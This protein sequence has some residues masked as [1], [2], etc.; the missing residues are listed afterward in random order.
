MEKFIITQSPPLKGTVRV[1][2]SKNAALPIL[3]ATLLT[4]AQCVIKDVPELLD[5][6]RME[7]YLQT[8]GADTQWQREKNKITVGVKKI[9]STEAPYPLACSMRASFLVMGPLLARAARVKIPLPG[10]C[11]IGARP[12]DQH[13]KGLAALG[14]EITQEHGMV[15]AKAKRL[16][17]ANIYLDFPSVG[18]TENIMMAAVLARGRTIIENSAI[19]PEIVDLAGFLN[20]I[21]AD[22]R[23]AG[24]DTIRI[25]GVRGLRGGEYTIIPDRIEAGTFMVAAA[26]TRGDVLIENIV[27]DHLKPVAAKLKEANAAVEEAETGL[28]VRYV[29]RGRLKRADIKTLPYPGFPTDMQAQFMSLL[30]LAEGTS[31]ITETIFENRFMHVGELK[32]MG[33]NIKIESRSAIVEGVEKLAGTQ[34]RTTDLRAGAAL[35]LSGLIA[36]GETEIDDI[37]HIDRG[38]CKIEE[39]LRGLGAKIKRVSS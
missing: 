10:G 19:E 18:A 31:I 8:F 11:A 15:Y 12:V 6:Q 32:R 2:G 14:A 39:K 26:L 38:Y 5:V 27:A 33:A 1:S 21:G 24:T 35:I 37:Y 4:E 9:A 34:V 3:A 28:Q 16:R 30:A 36:E 7:E 22:V 25:N 20:A 17:G 13:L 23:G 29:L